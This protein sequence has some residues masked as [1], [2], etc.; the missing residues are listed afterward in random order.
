MARRSNSQKKADALI[1]RFPVT[2][3]AKA[4]SLQGD[5][6]VRFLRQF[7][8]GHPVGTLT[9]LRQ[10][11]GRIYGAQPPLME[12]PVEDWPTIEKSLR[13][14]AP[15]D[16]LERNLELGADV[17]K[18]AREEGY[19]ATYV[20]TQVFRY[21]RGTAP[22][23]IE[24]YLTQGSRVLFQF[25]HLRK[26]SLTPQQAIALAS[27][28][29][30]AYAF[31]DFAEAEVEIVQFCKSKRNKYPHILCP[32]RSSLMSLKDLSKEIDEVYLILR[33]IAEEE[34]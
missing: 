30:H 8:K 25:Q 21:G 9:P 15:K 17:F 4:V 13:K 23:G 5:A 1:G 24:F 20:S 11:L 18:H 27:I 10:V 29:H 28:I 33:Q 6:R 12:L 32:D 14:L 16:A 34:L 7:V 3:L 22:I 26:E 31:G 2:D 19:Q